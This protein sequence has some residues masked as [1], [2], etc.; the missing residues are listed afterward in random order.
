MK[1][2]EQLP[3]F[4]EDDHYD[5]GGKNHK[6]CSKCDKKLPLSSFSRH[7]GGNYL[8]PECKKCNNELG[9]IRARLKEQHGMPKENY[10]CPIFL[11]Y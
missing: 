6:L 8:R 11:G 9:K 5:L 10:I 1:H 3:L 4:Y 7:S 2:T